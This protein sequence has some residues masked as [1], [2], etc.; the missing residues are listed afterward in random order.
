MTHKSRL[1]AGEMSVL[2]YSVV[3]AHVMELTVVYLAPPSGP[4]PPQVLFLLCLYMY[5]PI[6]SYCFASCPH[7]LLT[8]DLCH[9]SRSRC[10]TPF[11]CTQLFLVNLSQ[12]CGP[13]AGRCSL[14]DADRQRSSLLRRRVT[15]QQ[16]A[17]SFG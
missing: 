8:F 7:S 4:D 2:H 15:E 14:D 5:F 6:S 10:T 16:R 9:L 17:S 13:V 11:L 3:C 12:S 1:T